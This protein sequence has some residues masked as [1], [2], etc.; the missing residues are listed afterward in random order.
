MMF[1]AAIALLM[2]V[3]PTYGD[4]CFHQRHVGANVVILSTGQVVTPYVVPVAVPVGVVSQGYAYQ[5]VMPQATPAAQ[6][7]Y[8]THTAPNVANYG[9]L[10]AAGISKEEWQDFKKWRESQIVPSAT[11]SFVTQSCAACHT[12]QQR[13]VEALNLNHP[14]TDAQRIAAAA[15]VL[16]GRMPKG[17]TIDAKLRGDILGELMGVDAKPAPSVA[18]EPT[19]PPAP[20]PAN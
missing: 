14:L 9:V 4:Q 3:S 1:R 16:S 12:K 5:R 2:L 19:P 15:A 6:Q 11:A 13:A 17:R 7:G 18:A 10:E 20:T 8:G